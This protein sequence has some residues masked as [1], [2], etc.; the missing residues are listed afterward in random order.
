MPSLL[1]HPTIK[2]IAEKHGKTPAQI[3]LRWATQRSIAVIPKSN[4]QDRLAQNLDVLSFDLSKSEMDEISGLNKNQRF[5]DPL[6]VSLIH[7]SLCNRMPICSCS[8][9]STSLSMLEAKEW[10]EMFDCELYRY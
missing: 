10:R 2:K 8:T 6:H 5:N 4:N 1:E 3:L 9:E 7:T